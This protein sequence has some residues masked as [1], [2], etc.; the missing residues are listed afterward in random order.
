MDAIVTSYL[1]TVMLPGLGDKVNLRNTRELRTVSEAID[2]MRVGNF[3][4][5]SD[6]LMQ[7]FKAIEMSCTDGSWSVA[8]HLELIPESNIGITSRAER[9]DAATVEKSE[10]KLRRRSR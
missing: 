6:L 4:G 9:S 8:Q 3:A 5:A 10:R 1:T 2:M 7:R